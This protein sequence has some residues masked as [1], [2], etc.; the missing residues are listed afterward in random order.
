VL[1]MTGF[2]GAIVDENGVPEP[3]APL[4]QKPFRAGELQA[5]VHEILARV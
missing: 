5:R 3:T 2:D 1:F 4:I